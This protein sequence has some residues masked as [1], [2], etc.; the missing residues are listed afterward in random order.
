MIKRLFLFLLICLY[1]SGLFAQRQVEASGQI[2]DAQTK[3]N[4]EFCSVAVYN[5]KDSLISGAV[6]DDKGFFKI[7]LARGNYRFVSHFIG[8]KSDT[9]SLATIMENTFLGV[10]KLKS[11]EHFLKEVNVSTSSREKLID[12]DVQIVTDKL[13]AGT[14]TTSEVLGKLNGV[15]LDRFNNSIKVDNKDKVIILV[16]GMEKDQ[17]Y[18]K[19]ISPDRLK[20]IEVIRDPGGR[21][22]LEGYS[23]VINIILKQDYQGTEIYISDESLTDPD[24]VKSDYIFTQN[25]AS[26]TIN[27][28]YNRVNVYAKYGNQYNNFNLQS[29]SKKEYNNGVIIEKNPGSEKTMNTNVKEITNNYTIG[30]DYYLNPKH[31][32]SF[33]S[34]LNTQP[35]GNN[36]SESYNV[37]YIANGISS[38]NYSIE[39]NNKSNNSNLYGAMFYEGKLDENNKLN[40]NFTYSRYYNNYRS[41]YKENSLFTRIEEGIDNKKSTEFYFEYLHTFNAKTNLQVG[42]GNSSENLNNNHSATGESELQFE[43]SDF[44]N[45]LYSYFSWQQSKT[46]G[47][48]LGG[49]GETSTPNSD[50]QK[51]SYLIFQPYAD[52]KYKPM[53]YLDLKAKYR[54]GSNY[55]NIS[56]ANPFTSIL[57]QQSVRTGNPY[58]H[59]EVTHKISLETSI[60]DGLVRVEP[61]YNFSHNYITEIGKLRPDTIFEYNYT[62]AGKYTNYGVEGGITIPFGESIALQTDFNFFN[63]SILYANKT[64]NINDWT[65]T[66]Q[67]SYYH[68]KSGSVAVLKYQ[69]NIFKDITA[70]GYNKPDND[71]LIALIQKPFFNQKLNIMLLYFIPVNLGLDYDQGGY[72]KTDAYQETK[73]NDISFLKNIL[74]L[75]IKYRFNRGKSV[76]K[77]QKNIEQKT[78]KN[79]KGIF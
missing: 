59:P 35:S 5:S 56:Q 11:D 51:N 69:K 62:N 34:N 46:F 65:I 37:N 31:T 3:E 18:I 49:A 58:L 48:K 28:V 29:S 41:I 33:E 26:A 55:P 27:Y 63:S 42:Y 60:L 76:K 38:G 16:D 66:S 72:I 32:I 68:Q 77:T 25:K 30:I 10:F 22:G 39:T 52:I 57:D 44:R 4:L 70:Q 12:R 61:Y 13:R 78:E 36:T 19:N 71:Y 47:I 2:K 8:Y 14:S 15:K 20:K 54:S 79:S 6:T 1:C 50:G 9:T 17:E 40:S 7:P 45:K 67:L 64:N 53:E 24:A 74:L 75:E 73:F 23:A 21:Y 43:Y